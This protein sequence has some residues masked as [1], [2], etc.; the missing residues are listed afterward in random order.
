MLVKIEGKRRRGGQRMRWLDSIS[1]SMDMNLSK[2]WEIVKDSEAKT[3]VWQSMGL[4]RLG[5]DLATE[6][7]QQKT[8]SGSQL[9]S[10]EVTPESQISKSKDTPCPGEYQGNQP[11]IG[12][13]E[14]YITCPGHLCL[15]MLF[16]LILCNGLQTQ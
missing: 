1:D 9:S 4:Q 3:G 15:L 16:G 6:Q 5:Y 10:T 14:P 8:T 12:L 11:E 7:Q 2:L 13:R